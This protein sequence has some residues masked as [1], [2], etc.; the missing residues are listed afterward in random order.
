MS[1]VAEEPAL[2]A[3]NKEALA[4]KQNR[5]PYLSVIN[6]HLSSSAISSWLR[7]AGQRSPSMAPNTQL[8]RALLGGAHILTQAKI[9]FI[10][11]SGQNTPRGSLRRGV[12]VWPN[13]GTRDMTPCFSFGSFSVSVC[14]EFQ[15]HCP[16]RKWDK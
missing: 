2:R 11:S 10:I 13:H 15:A 16:S 4:R 5:G 14:H 1:L 9:F 3:P 6:P 12:W 8:P 7:I